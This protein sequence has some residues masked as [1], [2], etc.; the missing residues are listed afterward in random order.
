MS[1]KQ[2]V[3]LV[4]AWNDSVMVG[5]A[6]SVKRDDG[7]EL[8]TKTRSVAWVLGGHTAVVKVEGIAGGYL[9]TRCTPKI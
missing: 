4:A 1:L 5:A 7:S 6:V 9:L 8:E 2:Q 3:K